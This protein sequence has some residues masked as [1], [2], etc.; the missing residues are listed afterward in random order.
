MMLLELWDLPTHTVQGLVEDLRGQGVL[1]LQDL[2]LLQGQRHGRAVLGALA[3]GETHSVQTT[4]YLKG[5][6]EEEFS[7]RQSFLAD[8]D[9][10]TMSKCTSAACHR[11]STFLLFL[12]FTFWFRSLRRS[13]RLVVLR[14][15]GR[16]KEEEEE[17]SGRWKISIS[18]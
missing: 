1:L 5:L 2:T 3:A 14:E 10:D 12:A 16:P 13:G 17:S 8:T 9:D 11:I 18:F 15:R 7:G 4:T 6:E